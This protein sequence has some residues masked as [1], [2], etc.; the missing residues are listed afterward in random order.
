MA[1]PV[2][3]GGTGRSDGIDKETESRLR[4]QQAVQDDIT[5]E[6][7]ELAT[8]YDSAPC[9]L[10]TAYQRINHPLPPQASMKAP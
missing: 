8:R 10:W 4:S 9:A 3:H 7:I 1:S 5:E 2:P 6:L